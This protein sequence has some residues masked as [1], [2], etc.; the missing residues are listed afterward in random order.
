MTRSIGAHPTAPAMGGSGM[1]CA[2][3][4]TRP[5]LPEDRFYLEQAERFDRIADECSVPALVPYYRN[6]SDG[7][8]RLAGT[9]GGPIP[10]GKPGEIEFPDKP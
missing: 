3:I 5:R 9:R 2:R 6:L 4:Q 7:Y 1:D 10:K 8:R